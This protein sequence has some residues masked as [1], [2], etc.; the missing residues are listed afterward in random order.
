MQDSMTSCPVNLGLSYSVV[1]LEL[2]Y[3]DGLLVSS[4]FNIGISRNDGM[5]FRLFVETRFHSSIG[6]VAKGWLV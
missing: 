2:A 1:V 5:A 4:L 6:S 3:R